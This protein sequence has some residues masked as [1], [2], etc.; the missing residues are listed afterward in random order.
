MSK[1]AIKIYPAHYETSSRGGYGYVVTLGNRM[2][3]FCSKNY[4][5]DTTMNRLELRACIEAI[6]QCKYGWRIEFHSENK[7]VIYGIINYV[8]NGDRSRLKVNSDLWKKLFS[9]IDEHRDNDSSIH[10]Y[11]LRGSGDS[12]AS[13]ATKMAIKGMDSWDPKSCGKRAQS[14]IDKEY[15][16]K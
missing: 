2:K 6:E 3:K 11:W 9:K 15:Y 5:V 7:Y 1:E 14:Q 10:A 8:Q 12:F 13:M 4:Y 16:G